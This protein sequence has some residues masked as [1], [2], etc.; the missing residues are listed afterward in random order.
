[1]PTERRKPRSKRGTFIQFKE[2]NWEPILRL[3]RVYVDEF[4]WMGELE[5]SGGVRVQC[6]KHFWTRRHIHLDDEANG[7]VYRGEELYRPVPDEELKEIFD[8]VIRRPDPR[9]PLGCYEDA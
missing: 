9:E 6:Y 8:L 5:L 4:M 3:A 1:M 2:P 7:F